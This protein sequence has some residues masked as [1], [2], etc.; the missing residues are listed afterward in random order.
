MHHF[1]NIN[2]GNYGG[3]GGGEG[4]YEYGLE[5]QGYVGGRYVTVYGMN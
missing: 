5:S 1:I 4:Y 3:H 2:R